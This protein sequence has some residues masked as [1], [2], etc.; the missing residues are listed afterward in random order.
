[1]EGYP[2]YTAKSRKQIATY[3]IPFLKK[4][5]YRSM[6][7]HATK[8]SGTAHKKLLAV[9]PPKEASPSQASSDLFEY[10]ASSSYYFNLKIKHTQS[11]IQGEVG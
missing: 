5:I 3:R 7:V 8:M 1:M 6:F 4:Y 10:I 9:E 2:R 11:H